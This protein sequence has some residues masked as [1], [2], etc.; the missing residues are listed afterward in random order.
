MSYLSNIPNKNHFV[1]HYYK[2][3]AKISSNSGILSSYSYKK[4]CD[5]VFIFVSA[6]DKFVF[7]ATFKLEQDIVRAVNLKIHIVRHI[8]AIQKI[9]RLIN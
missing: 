8:Y 1:N 7:T 6:S 5:N 3:F 4:P 2:N 9:V